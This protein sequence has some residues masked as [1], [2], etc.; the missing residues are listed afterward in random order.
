[1]TTDPLPLWRSGLVLG[2]EA[3]PAT[4]ELPPPPA[5]GPRAPLNGPPFAPLPPPPPPPPPPAA[6]RRSAPPGESPVARHTN[7]PPP[8]PPPPPAFK[9]PATRLIWGPPLLP[10]A[11]T[12]IVSWSPGVTAKVP[13]APPPLPPAPG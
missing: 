3:L 11:P 5:P 7:D 4:N 9:L 1:M 10:V 2:F 12:R 8:P 13:L 6:A